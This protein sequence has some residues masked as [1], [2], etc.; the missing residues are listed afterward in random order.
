MN[1]PIYKLF[2]SKKLNPWYQLSREERGNLISQLDFAFERA[3]GKRPILLD[4]SWSSDKWYV[5]GVEIFPNIEAVQD[6]MV[7]LKKMEWSKYCESR[8]I[9]GTEYH[10]SF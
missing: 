5:S 6:Y 10:P 9:L 4:T 8:N 3:G 7:E 1:K 2:K